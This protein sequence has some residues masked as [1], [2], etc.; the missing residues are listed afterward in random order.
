[1]SRHL[2]IFGN[3]Y[4]GNLLAWL[5]ESA[6]LFV[7]QQVGYANFV[8]VNFDDV[9]FKAPGHRG[10]AILIYGRL[11]KHGRSSITLGLRAMVIEPETGTRKEVIS[12]R[13]TFVALDEEGTVFPYF[14]TDRYKEWCREKAMEMNL[15]IP[16]L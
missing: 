11:L 10:D 16:N 13:V 3:L 8:T 5:D 9:N 6:Y 15:M 2:N 7:Q 12:C 14:T 4:G 1:M